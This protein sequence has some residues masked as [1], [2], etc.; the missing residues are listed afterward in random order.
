MNAASRDEVFK[1]L[2]KQGIKA[3]K[4]VAAD[5]SKANG[6]I[7]GIRKRVLVAS[8][9]S[10]ALLAGLAVYLALRANRPVTTAQVV[11]ANPIPRQEIRGDR[12]RVEWAEPAILGSKVDRFLAQFAEPGRPY[13][14][15]EADWPSDADLISALNAETSY[16]AD[17]FT[18]QVLLAR[19]V[20]SIKAEMKAYLAGGGTPRDY[21]R[22]LVN[23]QDIEI[24]EREKV[25]RRLTELLDANKEA[26]AYSY[27]M[28]ANVRLQDMGIYPVSRPD[29]LLYYQPER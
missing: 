10:A 17:A 14:A 25:E 5:G 11:K 22:D 21:L 23:R 20:A 16:S 19:M 18:E 9:V 1:E 3:I 15:K 26:A 12:S 28:S 8:V 24:G 4:V 27:W 2:R 7:R 29:R 6:E 13:T